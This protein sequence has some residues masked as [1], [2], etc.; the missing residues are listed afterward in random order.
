LELP[1]TISDLFDRYRRVEV[2]TV[3]QN[4]NSDQ[5]RRDEPVYGVCVLVK[6][7]EDEYVLVRHTYDLPGIKKTTWTTPCGKVEEGETFEEAA[8]REV[9]EETGIDLRIT[10]L[11][12]V[13]QYEHL[14]EGQKRA[15]WYGIVFHGEAVSVPD[16]FES[17]EIAE[18][19][20]FMELPENFAGELRQYYKD[21]L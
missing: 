5:M 14:W 11:Y 2:V 7:K 6:T 1:G 21:L 17:H 9:H 12:K 8:V 4:L 13:F 3:I 10:G 15:E 18:L 19:R 20:K 16:H